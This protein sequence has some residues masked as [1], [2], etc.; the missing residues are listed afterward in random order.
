METISR[1]YPNIDTVRAYATLEEQ[2]DSGVDALREIQAMTQNHLIRSVAFVLKRADD[3][4]LQGPLAARAYAMKTL[5]ELIQPRKK[6]DTSILLASAT[7][8]VVYNQVAHLCDLYSDVAG[9]QMATEQPRVVMAHHR[10]RVEW[11]WLGT[12][13]DISLDSLTDDAPIEDWLRLG[14]RL[15]FLTEQLLADAAGR[16]RTATSDAKPLLKHLRRRHLELRAHLRQ[17]GMRLSPEELDQHS[18]FEQFALHLLADTKLDLTQWRSEAEHTE[19][20]LTHAT[21][22]V[23][24]P[25]DEPTVEGSDE[26]EEA[27]ELEKSVSVSETKK[28]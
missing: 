25:A 2:R 7:R 9:V 4:K 24:K 10:I 1:I 16:P 14:V 11:I 3:A 26:D 5:D 17:H 6:S 27:M 28:M 22:Y 13:L 20:L 23:Q 15:N 18:R 21:Q 19:K 12:L 8:L